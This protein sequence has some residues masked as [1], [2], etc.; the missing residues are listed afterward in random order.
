MCST[1]MIVMPS[2]VRMRRSHLGLVQPAQALI[3]EEQVRFGRQR[4]GQFQLLEPGRAEPGN[5]SCAIGRQ[6][7]QRQCPLR[8]SKSLGA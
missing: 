5:R 1:Q 6:A 4:L 3:G 7:D 2:S 8:R